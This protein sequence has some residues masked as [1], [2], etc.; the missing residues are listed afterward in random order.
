[1]REN[2]GKEQVWLAVWQ[3]QAKKKTQQRQLRAAANNQA[4]QLGRRRDAGWWLAGAVAGGSQREWEEEDVNCEF[5]FYEE[6][7]QCILDTHI[8]YVLV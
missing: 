1:M 6:D 3:K 4:V 7:K 2:R 8:H 5:L